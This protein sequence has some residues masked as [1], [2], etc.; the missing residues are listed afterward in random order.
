M[1]G[2]GP[3]P[4]AQHQRERDTK[5]RQ[6][7][8]IHLT[9]DGEIRGP[10]FPAWIDNPHPAALQW[11]ENIRCSPQA[12]VLEDTDWDIL[13]GAARGW[14]DFWRGTKTNATLLAELRLIGER[15][16]ATFVDRQ[17]AKIQISREDPA[18]AEVVQLRA[19]N[20]RA[21]VMA[22]MKGEKR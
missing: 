2:R 7:D 22:R 8:A 13:A 9:R 21:D 6:A 16:G 3:A 17:R 19:V 20:S 5:R 10:E 1:A 12:Q 4:K 11:W 15:Y 18:E 14:N